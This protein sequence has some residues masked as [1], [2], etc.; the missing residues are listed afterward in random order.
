[1]SSPKRKNNFSRHLIGWR[2]E[3]PQTLA[4][5]SLDVSLATYRNWEQGRNEPHPIMQSALLKQIQKYPLTPNL[6]SE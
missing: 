2:G 6:K 1:M 5:N 3:T 4:A